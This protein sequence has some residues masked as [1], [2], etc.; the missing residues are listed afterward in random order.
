M[1]VLV[2]CGAINNFISKQQ[3][4]ELNLNVEDT[5]EYSVEV[6]TGAI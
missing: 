5:P 4:E 2:D 6:R 3:V 1:L